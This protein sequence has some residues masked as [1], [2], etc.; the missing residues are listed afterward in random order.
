[1]SRLTWRRAARL[2]DGWISANS[3]Y[4]TLQGLLATLWEFRQEYGTDERT[5]FEVHAFDV[6]A[7]S[8]DDYRRLGD[9]GVTDICV[10]PWNP[11]DPG[12]GLQQKLAGIE[13]FASS[14]IE[15]F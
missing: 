9:L 12:L 13:R 3:D 2:G 11:Y 5:R 4:E 14:V 15:K 6:T 8:L 1:M 7:R 10:N